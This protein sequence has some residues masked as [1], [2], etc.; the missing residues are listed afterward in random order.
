MKTILLKTSIDYSFSRNKSPAETIT[1]KSDSQSKLDSNKLN[2][3]DYVTN[4]DEYQ[5]QRNQSLEQQRDNMLC[6]W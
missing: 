4:L 2:H 5:F 3:G 6:G 1:N